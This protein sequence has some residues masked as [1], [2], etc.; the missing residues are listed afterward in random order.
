M[1]GKTNLSISLPDGVRFVRIDRLKVLAVKL[2]V[3]GRN[4]RTMDEVRTMSIYSPPNPE[5]EELR[6]NRDKPKIVKVRLY[7]IRINKGGYDRTGQY[8]GIGL[9]LYHYEYEIDNEVYSF[10]FRAP[11]REKAKEIT[12]HWISLKHPADIKFAFYGDKVNVKR[13]NQETT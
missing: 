11:N 8:W 3:Y 9:P 4:N 6:F 7:H 5:Q 12:L 2:S 1:I 13:D 10:D